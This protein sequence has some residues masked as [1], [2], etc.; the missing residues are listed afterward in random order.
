MKTYIKGGFA[1]CYLPEMPDI[2][3]QRKIIIL[4]GTHPTQFYI[5]LFTENI[6]DKTA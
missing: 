6:T 1:I 5:C 3:L 4:P 2:V